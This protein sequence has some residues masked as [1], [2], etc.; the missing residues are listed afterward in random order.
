M[1]KDQIPRPAVMTAR[2]LLAIYRLDMCIAGNVA[3]P[4]VLVAVSLPPPIR[5]FDLEHTNVLID[6]RPHQHRVLMAW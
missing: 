5:T 1:E 4:N 6:C 3:R 2:P